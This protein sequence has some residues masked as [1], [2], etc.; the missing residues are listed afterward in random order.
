MLK[1]CSTQLNFNCICII[2]EAPKVFLA[3]SLQAGLEVKEGSEIPLEAHISGSPYPTITWLRNDDVIKP[4]EIKKR[5]TKIS[6]RKKDEVEEDEPFHLSL[7]ERLNIDNSRQGESLLA[8]RDSIRADHGTFTIRVENDHG[9]AK[10]SCEVNVLGRSSYLACVSFSSTQ[11][12]RMLS[13]AHHF[14]FLKQP[15]L[16][17]Q[18]TS[19]LKKF[20]EIPF[21]A[22]GNLLLTMAEVKY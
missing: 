22:N 19:F 21:F 2:T 10:A 5:V 9:S 14:L 15:H 1:F 20:E 3:T 18:S 13:G 11:K 7:P 17:L 12:G 16:D 8:V 6:R 4:E